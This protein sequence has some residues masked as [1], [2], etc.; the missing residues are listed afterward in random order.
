MK[1]RQKTTDDFNITLIQPDLELTEPREIYG[2]EFIGPFVYCT[3]TKKKPEEIYVGV[4]FS[5]K[6][7]FEDT[8]NVEPQPKQN[9][10]SGPDFLE[11]CIGPKDLVIHDGGRTFW[12]IFLQPKSKNTL[13][14]IDH[15]EITI[16]FNEG[17]EPG[18]NDPK[19]VTKV[20]P[21]DG[22]SH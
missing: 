16:D 8:I 4:Y 1:I 10:T 7:K 18:K 21:P 3:G 6:V 12:E 11:I 14:K 13:N 9:R 20:I 2:H 22:S 5:S 17:L 15:I 19:R